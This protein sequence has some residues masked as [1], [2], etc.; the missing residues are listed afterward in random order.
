MT[1]AWKYWTH[2]RLEMS[3]NL[4]RQEILVLK[5][6]FQQ[7][8]QVEATGDVPDSLVQ[9]RLSELRATDPLAAGCLRCFVSHQIL[10]VCTDLNQKFQLQRYF[11]QS[12]LLA[13][14][15]ND[16]NPLQSFESEAIY[17]P[18][19]CKITQSFQ[20]A[21]SSLA[22]WTKRLVLQHKDLYRA[23][24][25]SGIYIAS[26]W[27]ILNHTPPA[28]VQRQ[29]NG[30]IHQQQLERILLILTS[31]HAVYRQDR[32]L[33]GAGQRCPEP[34]PQQ[35]ERMAIHLTAAG[36]PHC[37]PEQIPPEQILRTLRGLAADLRQPQGVA[38]PLNDSLSAPNPQ[39]DEHEEFLA[40]YQIQVRRCLKQA[41]RQVFDARLAE[42]QQKNPA[43]AAAFMQALTLFF[44]NK[45]P[46][47]QIAPLVGLQKQFQVT[48]LLNL[49]QLRAEVRQQWLRLMHRELPQI[50]QQYLESEQ[51]AQ[52]D[53]LNRLTALLEESI[54]RIMAEDRAEC[55]SAGHRSESLFK[56]CLRRY[57]SEWQRDSA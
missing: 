15:L 18:L 21:Q 34:T 24:A 37:P 56:S 23:L 13:Y 49:T 19:A 3:G 38:I 14:V 35:L 8:F 41:I 1:V 42:L 4:K 6:F 52:V 46:M 12:E 22:Y 47:A 32:L 30:L 17:L 48:R 28:R 44:L 25:S 29:F 26:D 36:L 45:L 5:A 55:Y 33:A 10:A 51:I 20:P 27:A 53:Q 40:H 11:N 57:L 43:K 9:T 16:I 39:P 7:Q 31:F 50:L 2:V 54:D